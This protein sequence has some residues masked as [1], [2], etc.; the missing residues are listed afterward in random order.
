MT[1]Q[2]PLVMFTMLATIAVFLLPWRYVS[3][4]LSKGPAYALGLGIASVAILG[5]FFLPPRPNPLI[6]AGDF[7]AGM[8]F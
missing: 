7:V 4:K 1:E 3:K 6:Y 2:I 5:A 8:G